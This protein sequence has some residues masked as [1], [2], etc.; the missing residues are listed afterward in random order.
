MREEFEV[1]LTAFVLTVIITLTLSYIHE[2]GHADI[3]M[4]YGFE[5]KEFSI[6]PPY[7][8]CGVSVEDVI[9]G[10]INKSIVINYLEDQE[11]WEEMWFSRDESRI[12]LIEWLKELE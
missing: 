4:K 1:L 8:I 11:K 2:K 6:V 9:N 12:R 10:K 5:V 7:V 3:C